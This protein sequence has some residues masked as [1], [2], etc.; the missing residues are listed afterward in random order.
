MRAHEFVA[1]SIDILRNDVDD[2]LA[3]LKSQGKRAVSTDSFIE[4]LSGMGHNVTD[5]ALVQMLETN[6]F[7][8]QATTTMLT[9]KKDDIA[10]E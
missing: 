8:E 4:Q 9:L 5:V 3:S 7:V 10:E 6:P 1:E 2:L